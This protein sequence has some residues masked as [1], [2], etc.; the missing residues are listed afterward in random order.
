MGK[1]V[2][3]NAY[4]AING[5]ALS[6]H[7]NSLTIED[8]ADEIDFTAFS[9]NGYKEYG[10]GL[11]DATISVTFFQDFAANSVHAI[12]QPLYSSGG[13]FLVEVRPDATAAVSATNPKATMTAR[14][15]SYAGFGGAVGDA[16]TFDASFRNGGTAGLV[17]GTT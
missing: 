8:S 14:L 12:L 1:Y 3:R 9:P 4:I 2:H 6:D 11:K 15:Y 17:W 7:A 5:T 13:T 10:Q 16:S